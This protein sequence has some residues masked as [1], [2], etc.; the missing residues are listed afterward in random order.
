MMKQNLRYGSEG[1][2]VI[3]IRNS[4]CFVLVHLLPAPVLLLTLPWTGSLILGVV[5]LELEG[6]DTNG[7]VGGGTRC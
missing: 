1:H 4:N 5:V 2:Q 6:T 3:H 7:V